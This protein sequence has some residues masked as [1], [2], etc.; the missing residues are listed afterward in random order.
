MRFVLGQKYGFRA[1]LSRNRVMTLS[2]ATYDTIH[3]LDEDITLYGIYEKPGE[4]VTMEEL[5]RRYDEAG[6][7]VT[8]TFVNI[9]ENPAI[10]SAF[11]PQGNGLESGSVIVSNAAKT[12]YKVLS[13]YDLYMVS[14]AYGVVG[15][16]AEQAITSAIATINSGKTPTV[17]FAEGH[18]ELALESVSALITDLNTTNYKVST[19][20]L[21]TTDVELNTE[22]VLVFAG[23]QK[24]LTDE[25]F[26]QIREF[27]EQGGSVVILAS[28]VF[29][30]ETAG[31][32]QVQSDAMPNFEELMLAYSLKVNKDIIMGNNSAAIQ[33]NATSLITNIEPNSITGNM[34]KEGK[35]PVFSQASSIEV[36]LVASGQTEVTTLVVTDS[37]CY[38][39]DINSDIDTIEMQAGDVSGSFIVGAVAEGSGTLVLLSTA[40]IVS[41]SGYMA[42]D[43]RA[44]IRNVFAYLTDTPLLDIETKLLI[45]GVLDFK[46]GAMRTSLIV[47]SVALL[48]LLIM[49]AGALVLVKRRRNS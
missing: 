34:Y 2:D 36:P 9:I 41:N 46:S 43:N 15:I 22:D 32:V 29:V 30:D 19:L 26:M 6:T 25:E 38:V 3:S 44:L 40:S 13:Y 37:D 14:S 5:L 45:D 1:D 48:P 47:I 27:M 49:A 12:N 18:D 35:H 11:D 4:D 23:P 42:G 20:N 17:V 31:I 33:K 10:V 16:S 28:S 8:S 21:Q 39:K 24:D 7:R